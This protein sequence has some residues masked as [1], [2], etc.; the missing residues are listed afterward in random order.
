MLID[1]HLACISLC[2]VVLENLPRILP[3]VRESLTLAL[4][5]FGE[6]SVAAEDNEGK[7]V[8]ISYYDKALR[9]YPDSA[10][11]RNNFGGFLFKQVLIFIENIFENAA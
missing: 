5:N 11:L 6:E 4:R 2:F 9:L 8:A 10:L 1:E 7:T 3:L